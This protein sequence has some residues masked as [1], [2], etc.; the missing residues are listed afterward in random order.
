VIGSTTLAELRRRVSRGAEAVGAGISDRS[1][2]GEAVWPKAGTVAK[3]SR[4]KLRR[5][6]EAEV[7]E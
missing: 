2:T 3:S 4:V 1:I 5:M 7:S 6:I